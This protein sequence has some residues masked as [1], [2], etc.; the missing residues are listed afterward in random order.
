VIADPAAP[1]PVMR[2]IAYGPSGVMEQTIASLNEADTLIEQFPV[3]WI[4]VDGLGDAE[5]IK[6]FGT[7][8]GLHPLALEDVVNTHQRPKVEAYDSI[9]FFVAR[10][11]T[12]TQPGNG[13]RL[14]TDQL[15][16]FLGEKFVLSFQEKAGDCFDPVRARVRDAAG[17]FRRTGADYLVYALL[18]A[19]VDSYFPIVERLGEG[20][21]EVEERILREPCQHDVARLHNIKR[22]LFQMRRSAWPLREALNS[23]IRDAHPLIGDETRTHLRDCSDHTVQIIDLIETDREV[24]SD[25]RDIYLSA[26]SNRMN[27]V[28]KVLTIIST[29]F[30][31]LTFLAGVYGMNFHT[32][33]GPWSM[34]ELLWEY[35]YLAFWI[36]S[37]LIAGGLLALF[38]GLG[39]MGKGEK[40]GTSV[41]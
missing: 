22:D 31:P 23:V 27:Q 25:L 7:R 21:D 14:E 38:A 5:I 37:L 10:E 11:L 2:V 32:D 29:I 16:I 13:E 6:A 26:V 36:V 39:W 19:V 18:D 30:I 1:K 20:L 3:V 17:R 15:S 41:P 9:L 24:C 8:F 40:A 12:L 4:N 34:P 33:A 35:G 28:M